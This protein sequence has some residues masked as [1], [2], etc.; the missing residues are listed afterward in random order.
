VLIGHKFGGNVIESLVMEA[1][2]ILKNAR[3]PMR[4]KSNRAL[5]LF[6][7]NVVQIA[8]YGRQSIH[9]NEEL[10]KDFSIGHSCSLCLCN[11]KSAFVE[12]SYSNC[13]SVVFRQ[14]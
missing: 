6:V 3:L 2:G 14:E 9:D 8:V 4:D 1:T 12:V 7:T 5:M 11:L 10:N 13:I